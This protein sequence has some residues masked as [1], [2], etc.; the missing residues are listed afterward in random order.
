M[1]TTL[2]FDVYG[3]LI[4]TRGVQAS[5]QVMMDAPLAER[6]TELW[7]DKQ[8]EYSF[9]RALMGAYRDFGVCTRQALD[10]VCRALSVPLDEGDKES[11]LET[12]RQLPCFE[13][14]RPGLENLKALGLRM[15]AFSNGP[16]RQVQ[17]LLT[18]SGIDHYFDDVVSVDEIMTFKPDPAVYTHFLARAGSKAEHT[19]LISG[20]P[21]DVIGALGA[22]LRAAW[23]CRSAEAVFDP[24]E[25]E[26]TARIQTLSELYGVL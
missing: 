6:F 2:A 19:W 15:F 23:L 17:A 8:L 12:Y 7:R 10:Y 1:S 24:W 18:H 9:R 14:V 13:D 3:T 20:N 5:L 4:D 26:P 11:L 16:A 25:F 22:G 21:F